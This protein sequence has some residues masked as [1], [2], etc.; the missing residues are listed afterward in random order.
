M[1]CRTSACS[2]SRILSSRRELG[3]GDYPRPLQ[4]EGKV[5]TRTPLLLGPL[6]FWILQCTE[7]VGKDPTRAVL[8]EFE[9][10]GHVRNRLSPTGTER[11]V[12]KTKFADAG[13]YHRALVMT[14][15]DC[16]QGEQY[17]KN[18]ARPAQSAREAD[19]H[20]FTC[21]GRTEGE[22]C[23]KGREAPVLQWSV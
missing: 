14:G 4:R 8:R 13:V 16:S 10:I 20:R 6:T 23:R 22:S 19:D 21:S 3:T 17:C 7:R 5:T 15:A 9:F 11:R 18:D 1:Q 12:R 2:C